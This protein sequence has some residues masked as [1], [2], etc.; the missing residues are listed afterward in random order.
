MNRPTQ[1]VVSLITTLAITFVG[2][3]GASPASA[4]TPWPG[5]P[6]RHIVL[7]TVHSGDTATG[8]AVRFH[9]WTAE[10]LALNHLRADSVLRIGRVL[11][12]PVVN[13]AARRTHTTPKTHTTLR[14]RGWRHYRMSRVQVRHT[15]VRT[16]R[17]HN[18]PATLAL[19]IAW[20]ESGWHQPLVSS[21]GAIGVMQLLPGTGTWMSQYA[22]RRLN[23]R[24]TFDNVLGGVLLLDYLRANTRHDRR[25]IAAY[26]QGLG[27]VRADGLYPSTRRYVKS[28]RAIR[29]NLER[30]GSPTGR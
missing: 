15:V 6:G 4:S 7:H 29:H 27:G 9:A 1:L 5:H 25:A 18:V 10:L 14:S 3:L 2:M 11:K 16:A 20:Q 13:K 12:I 8:L 23:I 21:A 22:G 26:Y 24:D 28:V 30:T 17:Q 19:A